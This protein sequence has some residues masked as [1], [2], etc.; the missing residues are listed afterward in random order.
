MERKDPLLDWS[1]PVA[2]KMVPD[3]GDNPT[4]HPKFKGCRM[5][6][7]GPNEETLL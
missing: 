3:G 1:K 2:A 7:G 4:P 6:L 5:E